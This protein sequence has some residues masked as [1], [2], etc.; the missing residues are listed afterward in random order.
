MS[1]R[2]SFQGLV[3]DREEATEGFRE[4][5][6]RSFWSA[7]LEYCIPSVIWGKVRL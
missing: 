2:N 7:I 4:L 5:E 1:D 3:A 6:A